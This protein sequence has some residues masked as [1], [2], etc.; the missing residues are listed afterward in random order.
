[1]PWLAGLFP[2]L[3]GKVGKLAEAGVKIIAFA[4]EKA[5][6]QGGSLEV[7]DLL[8]IA[9]EENVLAGVQKLATK[10]ADALEEKLGLD[11]KVKLADEPV[12]PVKL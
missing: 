3:A 8:Q 4:R 10:K 6:K 12:E 1:M 11:F 7:K 2:V 5:E 9:K